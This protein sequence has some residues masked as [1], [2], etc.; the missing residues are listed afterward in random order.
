MPLSPTE[1]DAHLKQWKPLVLSMAKR[2]QA[3]LCAAHD[4]SDIVA[5][6][7][8][9][10]WAGALS[11]DAS[12]GISF[13]TYGG[14]CVLNAYLREVKSQNTTRRRVAYYSKRSLDET[15]EDDSPVLV[16]RSEALDAEAQLLKNID[17]RALEEALSALAAEQPR[18]ERL[19]RRKFWKGDT[20]KDIGD[21]FGVSR[22]RARQLETKA[23][24]MLRGE[25]ARAEMR[26]DAP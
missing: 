18:L 15:R 6:G 23:L 19:I 21:E 14:R 3:R 25:M 5:I 17:D 11:F 2:F 4:L 12:L 1:I 10:L 13:G 26:G 24:R 16:A 22:E 8:A 7:M 20:L 9:A